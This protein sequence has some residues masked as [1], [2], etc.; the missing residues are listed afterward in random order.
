[1]RKVAGRSMVCGRTCIMGRG[2]VWS[3]GEVSRCPRVLRF[4]G[5]RLIAE[6]GHQRERLLKRKR[7]LSVRANLRSAWFER[8]SRRSLEYG[9]GQLAQRAGHTPARE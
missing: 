3:G 6:K 7:S 5:W 4:P 2:D 9:P 1:V 8:A